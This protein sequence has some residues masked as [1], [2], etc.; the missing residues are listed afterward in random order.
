MAYKKRDKK[1]QIRLS[2]DEKNQLLKNADG[3]ELSTYLR[4]V[5]LKQKAQAPKPVSK[6]VIHTADPELIREISKIGINI[7]QMAKHL[8]ITQ[9]VDRSIFIELLKIRDD[10]NEVLE[11]V[12]KNDT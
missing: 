2:D 6:K 1:I 11:R 5:G 4:Q 3:L 10:L 12:I 9:E 8:N 7:N